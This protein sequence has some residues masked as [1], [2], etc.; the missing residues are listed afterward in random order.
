MVFPIHFMHF[1]TITVGSIHFINFRTIKGINDSKLAKNA[2]ILRKIKFSP[3]NS[4]FSRN[5]PHTPLSTVCE[6][7]L[8]WTNR[9]GDVPY[10]ITKTVDILITLYAT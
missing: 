9:K 1:R 6:F 3:N 7:Q 8:I 2:I 4:K 10:L 5:D